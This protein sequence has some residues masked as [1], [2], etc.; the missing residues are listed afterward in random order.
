[1]VPPAELATGCEFL[2][3]RAPQSIEG[4]GLGSREG[5]FQT[6][7]GTGYR[8]ARPR[9]GHAAAAAALRAD[10]AGRCAWRSPDR[11]RDEEGMRP[12]EQRGGTYR[13]RRLQ[14][15]DCRHAHVSADLESLSFQGD[16]LDVCSISLIF[17]R[18]QLFQSDAR[19]SP[20]EGGWRNR[21]DP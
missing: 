8:H 17:L 9:Q 16:V 3:C 6:L 15:L 19:V 18:S 5:S 10:L 21:R 20:D 1:M 2:G 14:P 13:E 7:G 12:I 4:F 11:D